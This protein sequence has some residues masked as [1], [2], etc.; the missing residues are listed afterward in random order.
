MKIHR[1]LRRKLR[2]ILPVIGQIARNN[3]ESGHVERID[4]LF[5][6]RILVAYI[7]KVE[8]NHQG[9]EDAFQI[10]YLFDTAFHIG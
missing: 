6:I 9:D 7:Y 8:D 10:I 5:R 3:Q 2:A 1:S 4:D